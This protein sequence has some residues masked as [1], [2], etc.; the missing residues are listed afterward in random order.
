MTELLKYD[1]GAGVEAFSTRRDSVLPYPV[2]QGH[3]VHEAKVAFIERPGMTREELE[4]YDVFMTTLPGVAIGVRTADCVPVLLYDPVKQ[5]VAVAHAG[6]KGTVLHVTEKTVK[7][8]TVKYGSNAADIRAVIG[9]SIGPDS[10][11]VGEEVAEYFKNAGFPMDEI[12]SFQGKG[13][14]T[15]MS[16][17]HHID[18]WKANQWL[19]QQAGVKPENIQVCGID[20]FTDPSFFSARREGL[21]CGRIINSIILDKRFY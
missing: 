10:F 2:I 16:G 8:M 21:Q 1:L 7:V 17:G 13:D 9:P 3:Q 18:L 14:G 11:Q 5:V 15:P 6:W 4:G 19:L 12:W 20:T